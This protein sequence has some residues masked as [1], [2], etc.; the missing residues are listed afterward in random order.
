MGSLFFFFFDIYLLCI[1]HYS[2]MF[3]LE[4]N[5]GISRRPISFL[6]HLSRALNDTQEGMLKGKIFFKW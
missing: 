3:L 5:N 4:F 1:L 6:Y 2:I